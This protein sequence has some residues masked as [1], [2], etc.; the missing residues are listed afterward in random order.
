MYAIMWFTFGTVF[1]MIV[2]A[3]GQHYGRKR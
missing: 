2:A 1:G 3:V